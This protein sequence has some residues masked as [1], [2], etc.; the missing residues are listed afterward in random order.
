MKKVIELIED[1]DVID[2]IPVLRQARETRKHLLSVQC[3]HMLFDWS[4]FQNRISGPKPEGESEY[5]ETVR[6]IEAFQRDGLKAPEGTTVMVFCHTM[7]DL[8]NMTEASTGRAFVQRKWTCEVTCYLEDG[9]QVLF[10]K[11]SK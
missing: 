4:M 6:L 3:H 10:F 8:P 5:T 1:G 11:D 9:K 2:C 7:W